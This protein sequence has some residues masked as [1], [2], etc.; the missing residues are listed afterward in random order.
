MLKNIELS[1][2]HDIRLLDM[3]LVTAGIILGDRSKLRRLA[4]FAVPLLQLEKLGRVGTQK[5]TTRQ[6]HA[7]VGAKKEDSLSV[8]G[9][10]LALVVTALIGVGGFILQSKAAKA[11]DETARDIDRAQEANEKERSD[12]KL[13]LE[14]ST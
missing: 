11:A 12:V 5:P 8:S 1:T 3:A 7:K 14:K 4:H 9:D 6:L 13:Q 10:M 2:L